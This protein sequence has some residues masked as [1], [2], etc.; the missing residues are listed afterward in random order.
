MAASDGIAGAAGG[1]VEPAGGEEA[2]DGAGAAVEELGGGVSR[3][4]RRSGTGGGLGSSLIAT[5]D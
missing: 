3:G 4:L 5:S 1:G 2:G